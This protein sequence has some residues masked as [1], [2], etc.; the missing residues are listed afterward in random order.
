[1]KV[2]EFFAGT[3]SVSKAFEKAGHQTFTIDWDQQHDNISWYVDVGEVTSEEILNRF[4]RPEIIWAS[5]DCKTYS[6][7]G[8]SHH[9]IQNLTEIL[10]PQVHTLNNVTERTNIC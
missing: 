7:A 4:G 10:R 3:R 2:L 6:V 9:R 5:P 8:I 1:M